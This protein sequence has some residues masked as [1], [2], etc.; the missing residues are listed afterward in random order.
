MSVTT[1]TVSIPPRVKSVQEWSQDLPPKPTDK[2]PLHIYLCDDAIGLLDKATHLGSSIW[3]LQL[4]LVRSLLK[5]TSTLPELPCIASS[6]QGFTDT[7]DTTQQL[8]T[9]YIPSMSCQDLSMVLSYGPRQQRLSR[10]WTNS[11]F[12]LYAWFRVCQIEQLML[13][14]ELCWELNQLQP[15]T[16]G[17]VLPALACHQ[18][19]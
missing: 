8:G 13:V 7:K 12:K 9:G 14:C 3:I 17:Q 16:P 10:P 4:T 2:L 11:I 6:I 15:D 19:R 5:V 1:G 18:S